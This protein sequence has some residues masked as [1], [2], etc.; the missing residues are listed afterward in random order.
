M[1]RRSHSNPVEFTINFYLSS[2][3]AAPMVPMPN[4]ATR[5]VVS[6]AQYPDPWHRVPAV[7]DDSYNSSNINNKNRTAC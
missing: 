5:P 6:L 1:V 2:K 4:P 7:A 3:L